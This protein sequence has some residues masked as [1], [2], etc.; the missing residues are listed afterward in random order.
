MLLVQF[1][2]PSMIMSSVLV[3]VE[4][5]LL[6]LFENVVKQSNSQIFIFDKLNEVKR[7]IKNFQPRQLATLYIWQ[8]NKSR[9][10]MCVK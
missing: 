9:F 10:V 1:Q 2:I 8:A 4:K 7:Y 5:I 6:S 3:Y